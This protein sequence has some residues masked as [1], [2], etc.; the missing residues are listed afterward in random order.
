MNVLKVMKI[1]LLQRA[2]IMK[3]IFVHNKKNIVRSIIMKMIVMP[4][5]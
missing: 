1:A 2:E 3:V 5:D 4:I